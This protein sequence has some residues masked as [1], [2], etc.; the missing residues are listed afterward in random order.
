MNYWL[1]HITLKKFFNKL[2][3]NNLTINLLILLVICKRVKY[4]C[5]WPQFTN[6]SRKCGQ[7]R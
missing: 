1:G 4:C 5:S 7:V 6:S 3:I 2:N